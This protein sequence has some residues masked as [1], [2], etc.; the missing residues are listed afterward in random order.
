LLY[1]VREGRL[2][3]FVEAVELAEGDVLVA[4]VHEED[5]E[6]LENWLHGL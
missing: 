1:L 4:F 2:L 3:P 6:D 5:A